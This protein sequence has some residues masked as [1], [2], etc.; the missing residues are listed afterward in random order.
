MTV[1]LCKRRSPRAAS[2]GWE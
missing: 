1:V 2:H